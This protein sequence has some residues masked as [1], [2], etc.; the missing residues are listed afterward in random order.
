MNFS[1]KP[2]KQTQNADLNTYLTVV[3]KD[4]LQNITLDKI[5]YTADHDQSIFSDE[6][7]SLLPTNGDIPDTASRY[8]MK[9]VIRSYIGINTPL[10]AS[11]ANKK[12]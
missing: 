1:K 3:H 2:G 10:S 8:L 6:V 7:K 4:S 12:E 5:I 9:R 11:S